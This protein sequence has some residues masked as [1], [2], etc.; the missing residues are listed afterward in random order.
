MA[1]SGFECARGG[2]I[3][4]SPGA[5]MSGLDS[6]SSAERIWGRFAARGLSSWERRPSIE[7]LPDPLDDGAAAGEAADY[8]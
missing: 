8:R 2:A 3:N 7:R 5:S 4:R 1:A 6:S